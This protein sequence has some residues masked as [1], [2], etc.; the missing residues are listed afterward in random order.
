MEPAAVTT[1]NKVVTDFNGL[2]VVPDAQDKVLFGQY[3]PGNGGEGG[4]GPTGKAC[5]VG[6]GLG[7]GHEDG[8]LGRPFGGKTETGH[9]FGNLRHRALGA[10]EYRLQLVL[11][12]STTLSMTD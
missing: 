11:S 8:A 5:P 7:P 10:Q 3:G 2:C 1:R 12:G 4:L 6:V 9:G